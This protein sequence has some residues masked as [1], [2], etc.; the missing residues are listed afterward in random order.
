VRE[1]GV[2]A[3]VLDRFVNFRDAHPELADRFIDV[4]YEDI[5]SDPL[6]AVRRIYGKFKM[7]LT[8]TAVERMRNLARQR[9]RYHHHR[10]PAQPGDFVKEPHADLSRFERYAARF[11]VGWGRPQAQ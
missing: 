8:D 11:K 4:R 2:L 5:V 3:E 7:P 6:A 1:S 10:A 9:S